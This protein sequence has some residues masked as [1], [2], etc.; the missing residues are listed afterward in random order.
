MFCF[1]RVRS[2]RVLRRRDTERFSSGTQTFD[3]A[4]YGAVRALSA[5]D[6]ARFQAQCGPTAAPM[7]EVPVAA[8]SAPASGPQVPAATANNRASCDE[9]RGTDYLSTEER[10]WYLSN[11]VTP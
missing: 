7:P 9:I 6:E 11:C 10:T 8:P 1:F 5:E 2:A 3:C 4:S